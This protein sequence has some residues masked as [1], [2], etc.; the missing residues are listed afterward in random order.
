MSTEPRRGL[1]P[2]GVLFALLFLFGFAI[3]LLEEAIR[4]P[5]LARA[6]GPYLDARAFVVENWF[7]VSVLVL[8]GLTLIALVLLGLK[9][10]SAGLN[11]WRDRVAGLAFKKESYDLP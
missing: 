7:F 5:S 1:G 10:L 8:C 6:L 11:R 2:F 9:K 4:H 3:A